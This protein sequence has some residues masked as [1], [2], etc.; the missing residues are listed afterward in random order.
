MSITTSRK[1]RFSTQTS[2]L[3]PR[4]QRNIPTSS[5]KRKPSRKCSERRCRSSFSEA[6]MEEAARARISK[7][8]LLYK[9]PSRE[10]SAK[11]TCSP[12]SMRVSALSTRKSSQSTGSTMKKH[13]I[14]KSKRGKSPL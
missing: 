5:S 1:T 12:S 4:M 7:S 14:L 9:R 6:S 2:F 8:T 13:M 10:I 11:E 3:K